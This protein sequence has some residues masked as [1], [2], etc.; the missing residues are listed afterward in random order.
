V[1]TISNGAFNG[2]ISLA[3]VNIPNS[4]INLSNSPF[5]GCIR[6]TRL[7]IP[8]SVVH[9]NNIGGHFKFNDI[10]FR[11]INPDADFTRDA[12]N[13]VILDKTG[14]ILLWGFEDTVAIPNTVTS[15]GQRAFSDCTSLTSI[16]IPDSVTSIGEYAF[17]KCTSLTSITIPSSVTSIGGSAFYNCTSLTSITIP[18]SVTSI[19]SQAFYSCTSLISITS[20]ATT[21]PTISSY[22]FWEIKSN[23]TLTV[24]AGSTGYDAWMEQLP[25]GWTLVEQ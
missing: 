16:T 13:K 5:A 17:Q 12:T 20:L 6:L 18:G 9:L 10:K 4:V 22:T 15:I 2:C 19:G 14:T 1:T 11:T 24:P 8:S 21:A 3:K 23:G 25:S 7:T